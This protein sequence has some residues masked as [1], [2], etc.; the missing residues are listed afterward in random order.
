MGGGLNTNNVF[1]NSFMQ[2]NLGEDRV[3]FSQEK[4]K[5][6]ESDPFSKI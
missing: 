5:A 2:E 6:E 3:A 4:H 1:S